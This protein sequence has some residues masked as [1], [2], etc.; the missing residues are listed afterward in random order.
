MQGALGDCW[1]LAA[2]ANL[3]LREELF[4]RVVPPDQSFT[5]NYAG[6][7]HFQFWRYG[8]WVDV[9]VDDKL[10]TVDGKLIYMHSQDHNEFWSA[11]LEKAY[12]KLYG[13]YEALK[14]GFTADALEDFT[15]GII[16]D[17]DIKDMPKEQL[18]ALIVRGFQMG[19]LYGCSIDADP[20]VTEAR[21]DNGLVRG[22]AY[23][24]TAVQT[25]SGPRGMTPILRIRNP[26]GNDAE[27]NGAWADNAREWDY[28]SYEE[29]HKM[30]VVFKN[31]G[32]FW[33]SFDDF[34][35]YFEKLEV[36]NLGPAVM[37]EIAEMTGADLPES[38]WTEFQCD[39]QWSNS[40]GTAGGC[41]NYDS[42][43]SN[44]Q[45]GTKI[46]VGQNTVENDGKATVIIALMQKF[47]RELRVQGLDNLPIGFNVY[48]LPQ[49][50][51]QDGGYIEHAHVVA[52]N[53]VYINSREVT[54]RF[55]VP[56]GE[57]LVIPSTFKPQQE[58]EFLLRI[59]TSGHVQAGYLS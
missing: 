59:Y 52:K 20:E 15:G 37:N 8:K 47:R 3:T 10:P 56:S 4:Y 14:G 16:E 40:Y 43:P 51:R 34:V 44:P 12:A 36:C 22:H 2:A 9:V 30:Q 17:Y 19:S 6:I 46:A 49:A 18:L 11:L 31:D 45:Y 39:G 26:W 35:N 38:A 50:R 28:V 41:K 58:A 5:E 42:F 25:V 21:C 23:S 54:A 1:F 13:S 48:D 33:M 27:W 29:K 32:E 24:I 7:F 53:P 57:Y 55:R